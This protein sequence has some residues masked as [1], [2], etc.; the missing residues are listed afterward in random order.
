MYLKYILF[1]LEFIADTFN[2]VAIPNKFWKP[3]KFL[4]QSLLASDWEAITMVQSGTTKQF[5]VKLA[6]IA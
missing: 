3:F 1:L 2:S 4:L 5:G 6:G